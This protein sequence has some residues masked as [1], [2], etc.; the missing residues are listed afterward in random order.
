MMVALGFTPIPDPTANLDL[1]DAMAAEWGPLPLPWLVA[2]MREE[3][4]AK[5]QGE[6]ALTESVGNALYPD[7]NLP[8]HIV[9][10]CGKRAA[11]GRTY[12]D[13]SGCGGGIG[14]GWVLSTRDM[15][16]WFEGNGAKDLPTFLAAA[17]KWGGT[18]TYAQR[19]DGLLGEIEGSAVPD[20]SAT[21]DQAAG[22]TPAPEGGS[23]VATTDAAAPAPAPSATVQAVASHPSVSSV[24]GG[25]VTTLTPV[26]QALT[27]DKTDAEKA[28][29]VSG[30]ATDAAVTLVDNLVQLPQPLEG[31]M[32]AAM[33]ALKPVI[34]KAVATEFEKAIHAVLG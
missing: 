16:A 8:T 27:S 7:P 10:M 5:L 9:S 14:H 6:G 11:N 24:I 28:S 33:A 2:I 23:T 19:V 25:I 3:G 29:I 26:F 34:Q 13:Y 15:A 1:L 21:V 18:S 4:T 22:T 31:L 30:I 20:A 12:A 32:D 17:Q